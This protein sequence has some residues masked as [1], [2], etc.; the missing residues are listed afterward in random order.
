MNVDELLDAATATALDVPWLLEQLAPVGAY[1]ERA[2]ERLRPFRRGDAAGARTNALRIVAAANEIDGR[3]V[4]A[5]RDA[6]RHAPDVAA[7]LARASMGDV[8]DDPAFLELL[9]FCDAWK[10]LGALAAEAPTL[11]WMPHAAVDELAATLERGRA[12]NAGF[13]LDDRFDPALSAARDAARV[14]QATYETAR[15]RLAASAAAILSRE[16]LDEEFIVMR[17]D[18]QGA[19]PPG[20]RVMR[21]AP[22]YLLCALELDEAA[23]ESLRRRDDAVQSVAAAEQAVRARLSSAVRARSAALELAA[24]RLGCIDVL[25]AQVRFAQRYA[26][27]APDIVDDASVEFESGRFLCLEDELRREGLDYA[28]IALDLQ[29]VAVLTGPNMGGK[30]V[31]LRTC[32]AIALCAAFGLPVPVGRAR[33]G[34]FDRIAWLGIGGDDQ[35]G[36]LLSSFAKEV[37]RLR[38]ILGHAPQRMLVLVDEFARTT[39]PHEGR[40]LL[41]AVIER[42]RES[43]DCALI[44]THL[45]G[46]AEAAR[47]RH[48]AV[49]GLRD[50]P[51][52]PADGDLEAS[53]ALLARSMDYTLIEVAREQVASADAIAL[54][55]LLGL[56]DRL[57]Q[58]AYDAL[59]E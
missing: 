12:G 1:G 52:R 17:A 46:V 56:D 41:V 8:L 55:A 36:G 9:R 33:V 37:V 42:L 2:F 35:R 20:V 27:V 43:G 49:R 16:H 21:E 54:A 14:A 57:I 10:R 30:S 23:L 50:I 39:T 19:L 48:F 34:L 24:D 15:G 11:A 58:S 29:G 4:D 26:C 31:A 40:A 44:A 18:L 51:A 3:R 59:K 32:G 38:E 28:P 45:A 22:T 47:V 6:L 53:L 13:Y 5:M 25:V 7:A